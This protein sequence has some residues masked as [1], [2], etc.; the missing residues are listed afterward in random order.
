MAALVS[1]VKLD[2]SMRTTRQGDHAE[3]VFAAEVSVVAAMPCAVDG[4]VSAVGKYELGARTEY[5]WRHFLKKSDQSKISSRRGGTSSAARLTQPTKKFVGW[6]Q[7]L[8]MLT[9]NTSD[10]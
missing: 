5:L 8:N 3:V 6:Q 4:C 9:K 1:D 7:S 2:L 10:A